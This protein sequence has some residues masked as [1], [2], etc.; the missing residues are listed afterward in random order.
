MESVQCRQRRHHYP[1]P[2]PPLPFFPLRTDLLFQQN[3]DAKWM[4]GASATWNPFAVQQRSVAGV[5]AERRPLLP[6]GLFTRDG[7]ALPHASLVL[8]SEEFTHNDEQPVRVS[9]A[10]PLSDGSP[11][12]EAF[13]CNRKWE[14][15]FYWLNFR[16]LFFDRLLPCTHLSSTSSKC[17]EATDRDF[18]HVLSTPFDIQIGDI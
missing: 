1:K 8:S 18:T 15:W 16:V 11:Q 14:I 7:A 4:S 9:S 13:S 2:P 10:W 17:C 3:R 12:I 6:H 5:R